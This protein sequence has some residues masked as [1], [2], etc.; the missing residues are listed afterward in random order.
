MRRT[1]LFL[2]L[3]ALLL[4]G[5]ALLAAVPAVHQTTLPNGL[6]VLVRE[7]HSAP[8]VSVYT[9]YKVGSRNEYPGRTGI[10]HLLEHMAF[11]G[12][13]HFAKGTVSR[14]ITSKGGWENGMTWLDYTAYVETLPRADLELA[15]RIEADRMS[16]LLLDPKEIEAEKTVVLSEL[17]G[18]E[19][20]PSFYLDTAVRGTAYLAHPYMFRTI[21]YKSDLQSYGRPQLLEWYRTYYAPSNATLVIVGDVAAD[22]ALALAKKHFGHLPRRPLP[23]PVVT[24]EPPQE[25]ERRM[26]VRRPGAANYIEAAY[27]VPPV[28]SLDRYPLDVAE[29]I[30]TSGRTSRL[31]RA[32]VD[33]GIAS[34]AGAYGY[35]NRDPTLF[36]FFITLREGVTPEKAEAALAQVIAGL[37]SEP[38]TAQELQKAVNQARAGFV[39]DMDSVSEQAYR[40][41]FYQTINSYRYLDTYLANIGKVTAADVQRV[42]KTYFTDENRTVGWFLPNAPGQAAGG[43]SGPSQLRGGANTLSPRE[44]VTDPEPGRRAGVSA[45]P[46][47]VAAAS[48]RPAASKPATAK[49][50]MP[51]TERYVLPNG[52]VLIV[53][54]NHAVPAVSL[55]G[56]IRAGAIYDPAGKAGLANLTAA[57][58]SRGAAGRSMQEI[59]QQLEFVAA[60]VGVGGGI[61][62]ANISG[63]CLTGDLDLTLGILADELRRP[64]FPEEQ[65]ARLKGQMETA[66]TEAEDDTGE[67]AERALYA[68]LYP[69][70][71]PL[72]HVPAG[73]LATVRTIT[74]QDMVDFHRQYY[75]PDTLIL[76]VVGDVEPAQVKTLVEKHFGDWQATGQPP[77]INLPPP[78][79]PAAPV[80]VKRPLAGKTQTDVAIGSVGLSRRDPDYY[81]ALMLNYVLGGGG[82]SS[83]LTETIRDEQGLA[84]DV[85]SQYRALWGDGPWVLRMGVNPKNVDRAVAGALAQ[86][87]R[88]QQTGPTDAELALWKDYLAGSLALRM[89]T[90]GGIAGNLA[91]AEFYQVGLD[92]PYRLPGIMA[93]ITKAQVLAA[94]KKYLHPE[95]YVLVEAGP[96]PE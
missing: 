1:W 43:P 59:A 6:T 46:T 76:V 69:A 78:P 54:A 96:V 61:Q 20:D 72:H 21:G 49:V 31:Y 5:A 18:R 53:Q 93:G 15:L 70:G 60:S 55:G 82:F 94:A 40:L 45:L 83:R 38:P 84:Y 68:A 32:L 75:R 2:V 9:W 92:Y 16:S 35:E 7:V 3:A 11:K 17:E 12:S 22:Q 10:S 66:L 57:G 85:Y 27:H 34:D 29:Y 63:R 42:A 86:M 91:D 28:G 77:A 88:I 50:T 87:E 30:L 41:G 81:S 65:I 58:L 19:N 44:R 39:Y 52:L 14:L 25:G 89:E 95:H 36:E 47:Q 51:P 90:N 23:P 62:V 74:R 13:A 79:L 4:Q 33:T 71:H 73:D 26:V 24:V 37:Q 64:D 48:A 80:V 67:V 8:V 56:M